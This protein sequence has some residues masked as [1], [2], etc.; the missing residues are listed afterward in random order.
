MGD[1]SPNVII[2]VYLQYIQL[3]TNS[4]IP[5]FTLLTSPFLRYHTYCVDPQQDQ[6]PT[7]LCLDLVLDL[8]F[9]NDCTCI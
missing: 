5:N 2:E 6:Q 3:N 4:L 8:D 7:G 1:H 9:M